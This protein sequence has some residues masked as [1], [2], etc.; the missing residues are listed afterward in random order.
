MGHSLGAFEASIIYN[1]PGLLGSNDRVMM[2]GIPSNVPSEMLMQGA[3]EADASVYS[4]P[5]DWISNRGADSDSGIDLNNLRLQLG[6]PINIVETHNG[7][8]GVT[9]KAHDRCRYQQSIYGSS[10]Q[11]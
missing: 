8:S 10:Y 9:N 7:N 4:A 2:L 1:I 11:C 6:V 5:N 3:G